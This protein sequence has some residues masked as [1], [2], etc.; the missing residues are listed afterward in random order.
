MHE[1]AEH[2]APLSLLPKFNVISETHTTIHNTLNLSLILF[3]CFANFFEKS[4]T[5]IILTQVLLYKITES[6][7]H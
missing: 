2:E 7:R 6:T 4:F 5:S 1:Y 3:R